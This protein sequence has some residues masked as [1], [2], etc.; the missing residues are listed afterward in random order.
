MPAI[1]FVAGPQLELLI[2]AKSKDNLVSTNITHDTE[3]RSIGATAGIEVEIKMLIVF[4][5]R[6]LQG[7][8][9]IGI[10]QRSSTKEFK[11]QAL[12]I[13]VGVRF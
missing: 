1:A 11:Y 7:F 9:H 3:E 12:S 13:T 2:N 8:N 5:A 4:S 10:G 6:Y